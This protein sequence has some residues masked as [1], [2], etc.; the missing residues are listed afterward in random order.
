MGKGHEDTTG[1][2]SSSRGRSETADGGCKPCHREGSGSHR[3]NQRQYRGRY[4][5]NRNHDVAIADLISPAYGAHLNKFPR[6]L[7][8]VQTTVCRI[9]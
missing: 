2:P 4:S 1:S 7:Q 8:G 6:W 3:E 5:R 9:L